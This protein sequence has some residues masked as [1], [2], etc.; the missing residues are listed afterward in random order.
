MPFVSVSM[1][2]LVKPTC[3]DA[4]KPKP[5]KKNV[6][7]L[8]VSVWVGCALARTFLEVPTQ[9][10]G[11][12]HDAVELGNK[13]GPH[14]GQLLR[15]VVNQYVGLGRAHLNRVLQHFL[16]RITVVVAKLG[17]KGEDRVIETN[18]GKKRHG[19]RSFNEN[20]RKGI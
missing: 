4:E 17:R 9:L 7:R 18:G 20:G 8:R 19:S 16:H 1:L 6:C 10:A 15:E 12:V 5:N 14:R 3:I 11:E 2:L 13:H